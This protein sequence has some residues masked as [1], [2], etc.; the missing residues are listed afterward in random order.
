MLVL[1]L[2]L[3][4]A[5]PAWAML[6]V[7]E[8]PARYPAYSG[9]VTTHM[10]PLKALQKACRLTRVEACAFPMRTWCVVYLPTGRTPQRLAALKRHELA[11]CSG[12]P[13]NHPR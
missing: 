12:W 9:K 4:L 5:I 2:G 11:H 7:I 13:A 10:L 3:T 6:T 1:A 8:P